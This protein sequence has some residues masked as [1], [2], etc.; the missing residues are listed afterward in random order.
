MIISVTMTIND[1]CSLEFIMVSQGKYNRELQLH[2]MNYFRAKPIKCY[3]CAVCGLFGDFKSNRMQTI[4][5]E[6]IVYRGWKNAFDEK[7]WTWERTYVESHF[8]YGAR[9][10]LENAIYIPT[11]SN[12]PENDDYNPCQDKSILNIVTAKCAEV[13]SSHALC[14]QSI[15][16]TYCEHLYSDCVIDACVG[17][18]GNSSLIDE[19]IEQFI[20]I[21]ILEEC[22]LCIGCFNSSNYNYI[23]FSTDYPSIYPTHEPTN[24]MLGVDNANKKQSGEEAQ[25]IIIL[26]GVA[27]VL[28]ALVLC[29]GILWRYRKNQQIELEETVVNLSHTAVTNV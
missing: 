9:R 14:C 13:K 11:Q 26:V 5:E 17:A 28:C 21:P 29:G 10:R 8:I 12:K 24:D 1:R 19:Q 4:Y 27:L 25:W 15:G 18:N 2:Q 20:T 16:G 6:Y 7:A 23:P 3:K 22:R